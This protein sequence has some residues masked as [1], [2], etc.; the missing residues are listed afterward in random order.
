VT[1]ASNTISGLTG[2]YSCLL[3]RQLVPYA[4]NL[5]GGNGIGVTIIANLDYSKNTGS[6][7]V[8]MADNFGKV[9]A[10]GTLYNM[11]GTFTEVKYNP[12]PN[13]YKLIVSPSDGSSSMDLIIMPVNGGN[14]I[15]IAT[16]ER[17]AA[18]APWS[19][20]CQKI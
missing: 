10:T 14:S 19:G 15:L 2:Q 4:S 7:G 9:G 16:G 1:H 3:N 13:A 20:V 18:K 6:F 5:T 17:E 12:V 11:S 8:F